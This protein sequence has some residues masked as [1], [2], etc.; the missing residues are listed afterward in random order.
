LSFAATLKSVKDS[1]T[2][3]RSSFG[4]HLMFTVPPAFAEGM[5]VAVTRSAKRI[6]GVRI[7]LPP[8]LATAGVAGRGVECAANPGEEKRSRGWCVEQRRAAKWRG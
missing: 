2:H 3:T 4:A 7:I 6:A 8:K 5:A 1:Y